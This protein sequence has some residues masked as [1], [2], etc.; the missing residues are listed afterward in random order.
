M[1][2]SQSFPHSDQMTGIVIQIGT[3]LFYQ[4]VTI[5]IQITS[6]DLFNRQY[7]GCIMIDRNGDYYDQSQ[8]VYSSRST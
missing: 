3:H 5:D 2:Q 7:I 8:A 4:F 1:Q 6:D